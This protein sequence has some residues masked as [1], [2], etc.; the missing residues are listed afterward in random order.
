MHCYLHLL[1]ALSVQ[2]YYMNF[3]NWHILNFLSSFPV[4]FGC[5]NWRF[6]E[7]NYHNEAELQAYRDFLIKGYQATKESFA[8]INKKVESNYYSMNYDVATYVMDP[9][10]TQSLDGLVTI[11]DDNTHAANTI[12][13]VGANTTFADDATLTL[14]FDG[15]SWYELTRSVND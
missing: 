5:L 13:I 8:Q 10:T 9:S 4:L 3:Q 12:D 11:V 15:T 1:F 2:N 14:I 7:V 6:Q